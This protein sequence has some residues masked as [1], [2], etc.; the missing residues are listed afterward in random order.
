M[1]MKTI[2]C[3]LFSLL[4]TFAVS[5]QKLR[6]TVNGNQ[7]VQVV[8]DGTT[9]NSDNFI[10]NEMV[11]SNL[12]LGSHSVTIYRMNQRGR[13]KQLYSSKLQIDGDREIHLSIGANGSISREEYS[14]NEAYGTRV[15]M[16]DASF[17]QTYFKIRNQRGQAAKVAETRALFNTANE[18]YTTYQVSRILQ[19][20]TTE[21]GR[22]ELA[23][24][25]YDNLS[26][27]DKVSQLYSL[28]NSQ[29]ARNDLQEYVRNYDLYGPTSVVTAMST[30]SFNQLHRN[31]TYKRGA[32]AKFNALTSTF[33]TSTN[34]FTTAQVIS[35]ITLVTNENHRLQLSKLAIDNI[36]NKENLT[37][38]F[39]LLTKQSNKDA[40]DLYIR[41]N[42]YNDSNY[43]YST[44]VAMSAADFAN[45]YSSIEREWLPGAEY[46]AA[47]EAL[48]NTSYHFTTAQVKQI[49]A[50]VSNETN[51]LNLAKLAFDNVVDQ[52]N[53]R[54]L[55]DLFSTQALKDELDS[56]L[57]TQHNYQ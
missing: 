22:L 51:R 28:L 36:V 46:S 48:N 33:N 57:K 20:I 11:L 56:Y 25:S 26:D 45:L 42:G 8:V 34:Y 13:A 14:S 43:T 31:I 49:I 53:F 55:Y 32:A 39:A 18:Y 9:Y 27:P 38:L 17:N 7:D 6:I 24:L 52:Q 37:Q 19:L 35:L 29:A 50:L 40:L 5:A 54:Q 44:R 41:T 12:S 15:P 10:N 16:S 2:T 1:V 23:K 4:F 21:S 30:S 47:A 3:L